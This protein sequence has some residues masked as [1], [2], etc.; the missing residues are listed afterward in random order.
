MAVPAEREARTAVARAAVAMVVGWV[1]DSVAAAKAAEVQAA[2]KAV[3]ALATVM[4]SV[5]LGEVQVAEATARVALAVVEAV[6]AP[7]VGTAVETAG[8]EEQAACMAGREG[9]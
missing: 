6:A 5:D 2:A 1:E 7:L 9:S 4:D 8:S 3:V